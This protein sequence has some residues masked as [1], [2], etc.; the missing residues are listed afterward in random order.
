[1]L[2]IKVGFIFSIFV[3]NDSFCLNRSIRASGGC[4]RACSNADFCNYDE[5]FYMSCHSKSIAKGSD[6][7]NSEDTR[8]LK[9]SCKYKLFS[10]S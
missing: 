4:D 6:E 3:K 5:S 10:R 9:P 1:V 7:H 8:A 2:R